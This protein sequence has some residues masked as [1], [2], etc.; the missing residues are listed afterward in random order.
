MQLPSQL[1]L[2]KKLDKFHAFFILATTIIL[3][4]SPV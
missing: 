3:F 4:S 2:P 1:H